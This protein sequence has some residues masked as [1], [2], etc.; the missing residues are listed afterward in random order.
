MTPSIRGSLLAA[1][2]VAASLAAPSSAAASFDNL[3]GEAFFDAP[4][5]SAAPFD[6]TTAQ[7]DSNKLGEEPT[8]INFPANYLACGGWGAKTAWVR[9][10]TAVE[11]NLRVDVKK[12]TPGGDLFYTVYTAP[13]ATPAFSDLHFLACQDGFKGTEESYSFGHEVPANTVVFVQVLVECREAEPQCT[14][15]ERADALGGPTTVRLRFTPKNS[16]GDSFPDSVDACPNV[17]G[18]FRG[19]LDA[20][21]DNVGD[22]DDACP[23]V[24]GRAANGCRLGDEDGDGYAAK[25]QGGADCDDDNPSLSPGTRD[26]PHN[27]VDENC[28]GRDSAYPRVENEVA[29]LSAWSPRLKRTVGF[30]AAFKVAGPFA[31]GMIV[32]LRCQ[33][34]GCPFSR[35]A[36]TAH[37]G[38]HS[39]PIG[40]ELVG[41]TLAPG[42]KVTLSITRPEYIGEALRYTI[43]KQGKVKVETLCVLPG[44]TSPQK[45]CQ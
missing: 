9:F 6:A 33:G 44:G 19:C 10:P 45:K 5:R 1:V 40:G 11:G 14:D 39:V 28:D 32:R 34:R 21:G 38:A 30:L 2:L 35:Q 36:V 18:Q 15:M 20:D 41:S 31:K 29:A 26:V 8:E 42:A 37:A 22:A 27:G 23:G 3:P 12:A 24:P 17:V 25:A 43:R 4:Y 7:F 13:T 16:D